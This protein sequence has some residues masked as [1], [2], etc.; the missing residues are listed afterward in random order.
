MEIPEAREIALDEV[1]DAEIESERYVR[2]EY[3]TSVIIMP[4][5][6]YSHNKSTQ[7][8]HT[9]TKFSFQFNT[10]FFCIVQSLL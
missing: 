4:H 3:R 7:L 1:I 5:Y 9:S 2:S 6:D 10:I 8:M